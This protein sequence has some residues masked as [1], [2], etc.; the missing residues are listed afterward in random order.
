MLV[1]CRVNKVDFTQRTAWRPAHGEV[2]LCGP[3]D[4]A[5]AERRVREG[6][7]PVPG[8]RW[9]GQEEADSD[10]KQRTEF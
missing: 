10:A 9:L 7:L 1:G 3:R 5:A 6:A 4:G 2:M 8:A